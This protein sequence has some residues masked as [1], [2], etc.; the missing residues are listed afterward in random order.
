MKARVLVV[1][2]TVLVLASTAGAAGGDRPLK[3]RLDLTL[4]KKTDGGTTFAHKGRASGAL[5][6]SVTSRITIK[7]SVELKGTATIKTR[8]GTLRMKIDGRARSLGLRVKFTGKATIFG[9]SGRYKDAEGSG[10]FTGVVNRSTWH[11]TI[12]A[13]GTFTY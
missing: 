9:G 6:G 12:D 8:T 1:V 11:A 3:E 10:T 4:V 2:T 5:V 13:K 7:H